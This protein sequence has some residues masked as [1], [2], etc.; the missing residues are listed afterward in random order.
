MWAVML[1]PRYCTAFYGVVLTWNVVIGLGGRIIDH[2]GGMHGA[3]QDDT[4][5]L[6]AKSPAPPLTSMCFCSLMI[7]LILF[8]SYNTLIVTKYGRAR[9]IFIKLSVQTSQPNSFFACL[10]NRHILDISSG[11]RYNTLQSSSRTHRPQHNH[12]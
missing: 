7:H 3:S 10:R 2:A 1:H 8:K 6:A 4:R 12:Q 11:T 9:H 5:S